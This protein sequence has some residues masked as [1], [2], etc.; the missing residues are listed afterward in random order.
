MGV[1]MERTEENLAKVLNNFESILSKAEESAKRG[2][3]MVVGGL[4]NLC[5]SIPHDLSK[6]AEDE[7]REYIR[8]GVSF[9]AQ[10]SE[11]PDYI[12]I[13]TQTH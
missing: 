6:G 8:K 5:Y 1:K 4:I 7:V 11:P 2:P 3:S 9:I 12:V 10:Y 13:R